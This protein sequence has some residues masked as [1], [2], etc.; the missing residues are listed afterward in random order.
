MKGGSQMKID[1][2]VIERRPFE[3]EFSETTKTLIDLMDGVAAELGRHWSFAGGFARDNYLG[4][5][6]NDYDICIQRSHKARHILEKANLV[7]LGR[8]VGSEIPHDYF[9]D[10]YDFSGKQYPIHW[11]D[12]DDEWALAPKHFDFSIN[13]ICLKSDGFYHAPDYAW[14]DIDNKVLRK[15]TDRMTTNLIMRAIR[16]TAKYDL[17]I[18]STFPDEIDKHLVNERI[19]NDIILHNAKTMVEDEVGD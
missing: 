3:G 10:P 6:W 5:P 17:R 4:T 13:H 11:I 12:A 19:G 8:Q 2:P 7:S 1:I 16:F 14:R 18:D 9:I 15:M